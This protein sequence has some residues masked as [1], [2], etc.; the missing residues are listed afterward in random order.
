MNQV[1]FRQIVADAL[2][3]WDEKPE[4]DRLAGDLISGLRRHGYAIHREAD[5]MRLPP[6]GGRPMTEAEQ[7]AVAESTRGR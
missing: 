3:W 5:C 1:T 4:T 2:E 6:V 7:R